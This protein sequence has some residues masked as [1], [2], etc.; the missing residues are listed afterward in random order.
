[1]MRLEILP[2]SFTVC[3][4]KENPSSLPPFSFLART[5][6]EISLVCPVKDAPKETLAREDGWRGFRIQGVLD[7]SLVG[8]LARI[9]GILA[10]RKIPIFALSTY[11][12]DYILVKG[13]YL[14][15]A[16][17]ALGEAGYEIEEP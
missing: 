7:F 9:A 16:R 17:E 12:T 15:A 4:V 6:E 3:K 10:E 1:M 2:E 8:I 5:D 14:P 13:K 11:N